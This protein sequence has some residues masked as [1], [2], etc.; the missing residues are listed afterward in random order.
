MGRKNGSEYTTDLPLVVY[1]QGDSSALG[2]CTL[3]HGLIQIC[4]N[5]N[6]GIMAMAHIKHMHGNLKIE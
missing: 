4:I 5:H 3:K 6:T 2:T 1:S